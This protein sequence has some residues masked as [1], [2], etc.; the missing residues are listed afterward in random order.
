[1]QFD[2]VTQYWLIPGFMTLTGE[3]CSRF[4]DI[5]TRVQAANTS[6]T[7][8]RTT[9]TNLC[10]GETTTTTQWWPEKRQCSAVGSRD[11][12]AARWDLA[13][14]AVC[15]SL[16]LFHL[17][18]SGRVGQR[19]E[20]GGSPEL[21]L[22]SDQVPW[23]RS[24]PFGSGWERLADPWSHR[25]ERIGAMTS[26]V[27]G[28]MQGS[29]GRLGGDRGWWLFPGSAPFICRQTWAAAKSVICVI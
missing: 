14:R 22:G 12:P 26:V 27:A 13:S 16:I 28:S 23:Y 29:Q 11:W 1:M 15:T 4:Q 3:I 2:S 6:T 25:R 10:P 8:T 7:I 20:S 19:S 21:W 18:S 17:F 5:F 9:S 24:I